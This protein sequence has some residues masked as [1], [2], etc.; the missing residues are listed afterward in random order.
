VLA[1]YKQGLGLK[2]NQVVFVVHGRAALHDE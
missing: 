2:L 1:L